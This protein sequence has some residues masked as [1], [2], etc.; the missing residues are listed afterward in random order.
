ML[1]NHVD[2]THSKFY[3]HAQSHYLVRLIRPQHFFNKYFQ[4][5][6]S[7]MEQGTYKDILMKKLGM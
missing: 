6:G 3:F 7:G 5:P 2:I 1:Q 4:V